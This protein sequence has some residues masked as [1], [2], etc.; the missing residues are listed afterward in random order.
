MGEISQATFLCTHTADILSAAVLARAVM[1]KDIEPLQPVAFPLDVLAQI[2]D[3]P[4]PTALEIEQRT[5]SVAE[6]PLP[7]P[8]PYVP[9]SSPSW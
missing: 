6:E 1:Q 2:L 9:G 8:S 4:R 5:K 3:E 7:M